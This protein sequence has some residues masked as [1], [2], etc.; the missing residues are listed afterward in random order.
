MEEKGT[1]FIREEGAG[2]AL[3]L[4]HGFCESHKV[5]DDFAKP[6]ARDYHVLQVDLPG[7]GS[8]ASVIGLKS[9]EDVARRVYNALVAKGINK[10]CLIG[11]SLGGYVALAIEAMFSSAV[12]GLVLFHST[13]K[14]DT[15]EKRENRNKVVEFIKANGVAPFIENFIPPLFAD[16]T[17]P[18]IAQAKLMGHASPQE[19][20][21]WYT[22]AMRDRPD[23]T[24][25]LAKAEKPVML[26]AGERDSV[27]PKKTLEDQV[28]FLK[29]PTFIALD[30]S[31]HMGMFEQP[32]ESMQALRQFIGQ[33][34]G[35]A[36]YV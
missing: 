2:F 12:A 14:A 4:L 13:A 21:I 16:P 29:E 30:R 20:V 3:V 18:A 15:P 27:I 24:D 34:P 17:H 25:T 7:F 35:S 33:L 11:H 32:V 31:A 28:T 5:W 9:L 23:R 19:T 26:I 8:S 36:V 1:I 10:F 6:L 22:E